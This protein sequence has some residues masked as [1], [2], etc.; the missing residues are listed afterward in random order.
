MHNT[1]AFVQWTLT[2]LIVLVCS[3]N[4]VPKLH[5]AKSCHP[6]TEISERKL[7]PTGRR[8]PVGFLLTGV[9]FFQ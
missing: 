7:T 6:L 9:C 5:Q 1:K 2:K 3:R 4:Q 8:K